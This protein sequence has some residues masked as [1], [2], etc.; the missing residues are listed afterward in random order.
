MMRR[1]SSTVEPGDVIVGMRPSTAVEPASVAE[2]A[3]TMRA[4]AVDRLAVAFVGG[5]T[6][7]ELGAAPA[8]LD[9][10]LRT[11]R[12]ARIREHAPSDQIVAVEGGMTVAALQRAVAP[13]GQR[14]ALDP[15]DPERATVGGVVAANAF[16]PRRTRHGAVRDLVIGVTL[17]RADGV[18]AHGG[19]KVVKNTAV[20][21]ASGSGC[22]RKTTSATRPSVPRE[23]HRRRGRSKP[24]T[25]FTTLPPPWAMTPSA[26]TSV[27]PM[28]RSRTAPNRVRRGPNA[29]AATT[30]PTVARSGSGGSRARRWPWGARARWRAATVMPDSTATI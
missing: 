1:D 18:V 22:R 10:V 2:A 13:H 14:L 30:P 12:L 29:F 3:E 27:T 23:P 15:P 28:T 4:L 17:V 19:G 11:R 20:P 5:G 7:L 9:V 24:A 26:R 8:R 16:G 21:D 6:D 25:F